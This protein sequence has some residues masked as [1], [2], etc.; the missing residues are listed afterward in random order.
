MR[1]LRFSTDGIS[2]AQR[3]LAF[4][5][6]ICSLLQPQVE[7]TLPLESQL[8]SAGLFPARAKM[9]G[10]YGRR[11]R[12]A[13]WKM[14]PH[15]TSVPG[16]IQ[17]CLPRMFVM[18]LT[19]G[20]ARLSQGGRT[21][22]LSPGEFCLIDPAR[23]FMMESEEI[24]CH[25][26]YLEREI[27]EAA[28]PGARELTARMVDGRHGTGALFKSF[29][30][31]AIGMAPGLEESVADSIAQAL[32]YVLAAALAPKASDVTH[33]NS[34]VREL[35]LQRVRRF[36]LEHLH[37]GALTVEMIAAGVRLTKRHLYDLFS[38]EP[39]TLMKWILNERLERCRRDLE[40]RTLSS[41]PIGEIAYT[42]GFT[43]NAHFSRTFRRVYGSSPR[44]WRQK[45]RRP[46]LDP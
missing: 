11:L 27:V 44:V 40:S 29:A 32:P 24:A 25:S 12:F 33:G 7:G 46:V 41:L 34:K 39:A 3:P 31:E 19:R 36:A 4:Q 23:P 15:S 21:C 18:M 8:Q 42:W 26:L 16:R 37:D 30:E 9:D 2:G 28:I 1:H 20:Q 45:A 13:S 35:Q 14:S 43:N 22:V 5:Q 6:Q 10:Y 38:N 17:A